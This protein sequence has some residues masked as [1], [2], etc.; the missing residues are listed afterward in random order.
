MRKINRK[1]ILLSLIL[2]TAMVSGSNI[3][4]SSVKKSYANKNYELIETSKN[5]IELS[6]KNNDYDL[7]INTLKGL[8][9]NETVSR[10]QFSVLVNAYNLFKQNKNA[11]AVQ[12]LKD[13]K[14][15]PVLIKFINNRPD[16]TEKQKEI[17][18]QASDLIKQG[19]TDEAKELIKNA[20]LPEYPAKIDKKINKVETKVKNN[21][22]KAAFEKARQLKKEGKI[23][24]AKKVLKD[25]GIPETVQEKIRPEFE[26]NNTDEKIGLFQSFKNLFIK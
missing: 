18:K 10:D 7:F 21:E 24:E 6:L 19:K 4:A 12:L 25:A 22:L 15:N 9:I 5:S 1:I 13:N 3:N 14:V 26:K 2:A 23:D 17:L 16:L 8:S 11:E 20:G